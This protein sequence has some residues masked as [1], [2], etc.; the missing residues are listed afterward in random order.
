MLPQLTEEERLQFVE[1]L[2]DVA[3]RGEKAWGMYSDGITT[4]SKLAIYGTVYHEAFHAVFDQYL[5]EEEK[6][7]LL[8]EAKESFH[9]GEVDDET[10]EEALAE[11][12]KHF[13]IN[14]NQQGF[15]KEY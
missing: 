3:E 12:F 1:D 4:I 6:A 14:P 11:G 2:I 9:L 15:G 5:N 10:A 7:A 13:M 8:I